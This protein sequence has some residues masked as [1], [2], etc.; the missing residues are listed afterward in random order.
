MKYVLWVLQ[1]LVALFFIAAVGGRYLQP[2]EAV[3]NN[4][5]TAWAADIPPLLLVVISLLEVA[6]AIG[7]ILPAV[8]GIRPELTAWAAVGLCLTMIGAAIFHI[9]RG[10]IVP[11][12]LLNLMW[13]AFCGFIAYGRLVL[14]PIPP[15]GA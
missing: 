12:V 9:T 5:M 11:S 3:I 13:A 7:L 1:V 10:E 15:R 4:P 6:G 14:R 2:W 8:T